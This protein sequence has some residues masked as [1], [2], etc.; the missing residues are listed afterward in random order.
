MEHN[1][2]EALNNIMGLLKKKLE[3]C[4]RD[5]TLS[6]SSTENGH[7]IDQGNRKYKSDN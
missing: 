1:F 7:Y 4:P 6:T 3:K 2:R 5:W